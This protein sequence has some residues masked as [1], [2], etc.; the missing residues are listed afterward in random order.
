M[1]DLRKQYDAFTANNDHGSAAALL[2]SAYGS[3]EEQEEVREINIRNNRM[4]ATH[5]AD[6]IKRDALASKYFTILINQPKIEDTAISLYD[7]KGQAAVIEYGATL[8][9][10]FKPCKPCER[11]SPALGDSCL[12]CG[13]AITTV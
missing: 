3:K 1:K 4:G 6:R 9:L 12:V 7:L 2:V 13:S 11:D 10:P 5:E 8:G